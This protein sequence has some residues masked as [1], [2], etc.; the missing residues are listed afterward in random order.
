M[1]L[2]T[3][4]TGTVGRHLVLELKTRS[5]PFRILTRD[6]DKARIKLGP[7]ETRVGSLAR[8]DLAAKAL[9]GADAVFLLSPLDPELP[10]WETAFVRAAAKAGVKRLVKLSALGADPRSPAAP[11]RWH[12]EAEAEVR[13]CGVPSAVLR[14]AAFHQ[15][16]L[17]SADSVR[18]GTLAAPMGNARVAMVDARD[19][20]AAAAALL[21]APAPSVETF[22]LTGPAPLS[23]AEVAAVFA[24]VLGR[25]VAYAAA[26]PAD[27]RRAMTVAGLP[28]WRVDA[29]LGLAERWRAGDADLAA[30]GVRATTGREP[31]GLGA[32]VRDHRAAFA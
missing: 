20:A 28:A 25:P 12:G 27:A 31:L 22:A 8:P 23:Y 24:D 11:L 26:D 5:V 3:G 15:N 9:E 4:A 14:P 30:D 6:P 2:V 17:A 32:F 18:R 7:V 29:L 19:A 1:I 10:S 16:L 13:R 21:C